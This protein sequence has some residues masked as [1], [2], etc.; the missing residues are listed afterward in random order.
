MVYITVVLFLAG[1]F[2]DDKYK[3]QNK[4]KTAYICDA[5]NVLANL[6]LSCN[7]FFTIV[8]YTFLKDFFQLKTYLAINS[9]KNGKGSKC[10][11]DY[12]YFPRPKLS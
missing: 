8:L 3:K 12:W 1:H 9:A 5:L 7:I 2:G 6:S 11:S 4:Q 10:F